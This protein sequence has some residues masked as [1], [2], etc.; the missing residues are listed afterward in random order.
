MLKALSPIV[1]VALA[2]AEE[3]CEQ[4]ATAGTADDRDFGRKM[5]RRW[6]LVAQAEEF[7][8]RTAIMIE[9]NRTKT[10]N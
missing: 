7:A 2:R 6:L 3:A 1:A 10:L 9:E 5:E 4:V 8:E